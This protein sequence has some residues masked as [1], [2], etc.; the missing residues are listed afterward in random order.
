[1]LEFQC[2]PVGGIEIQLSGVKDLQFVV[3]PAFDIFE[4][5]ICYVPIRQGRCQTEGGAEQ[6]EEIGDLLYRIARFVLGAI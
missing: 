3:N 4:K 5:A 6:P 1:M 2:A